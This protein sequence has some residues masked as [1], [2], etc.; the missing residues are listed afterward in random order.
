MSIVVKLVKQQHTWCSPTKWGFGRL[1]L[2]VERHFSIDPRRSNG[3]ESITK[4][5]IV[6]LVLFEKNGTFIGIGL[7]SILGYCV[8]NDGQMVFI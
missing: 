4:H 2:E 6:K 7:E 1:D 3:S 8:V 5:S